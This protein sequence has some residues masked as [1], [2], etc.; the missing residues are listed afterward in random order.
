MA[1]HATES[2]K[3][4]VEN[5]LA[6]ALRWLRVD[7]LKNVGEK[8]DLGLQQRSTNFSCKGP[9]GKYFTLVSQTVSVGSS[10]SCNY[11]TKATIDNM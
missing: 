2:A 4:L 8:R 11:R 3:L 5:L 10:Q 6:L 9:G 1:N 7:L